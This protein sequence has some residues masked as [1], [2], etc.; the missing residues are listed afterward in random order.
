[1]TDSA[2]G[3]GPIQCVVVTPEQ[4]LL[5]ETA[6]FVALPAYDGQIGILRGRAPLVSSLGHG[7]M[8]LL[9]GDRVQ[10]FYIQGGFLQVRS[11]VVTVL[12]NDAVPVDELQPETIEESL[13]QARLL[14]TPDPEA[15]AK[16]FEAISQAR[17]KK[18][19]LAQTKGQ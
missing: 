14:P 11:D 7:E 12:T 19:L 4:T 1:M 10:R 5:D 3:A 18:R 9:R 16:K 8:R 6:D 15:D 2:A 17:A 13:A